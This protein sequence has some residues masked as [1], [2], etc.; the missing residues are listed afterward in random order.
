METKEDKVA[1]SWV[2]REAARK[3]WGKNKYKNKERLWWWG[4]VRRK[5]RQGTKMEFALRKHAADINF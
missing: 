3:L 1:R 5:E 4:W 2:K